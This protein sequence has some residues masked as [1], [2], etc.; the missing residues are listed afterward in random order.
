MGQVS[1]LKT[2]RS[3]LVSLSILTLVFYTSCGSRLFPEKVELNRSWRFRYDPDRVGLQQKWYFSNTSL[4]DWLTV[5]G[6]SYWDTNYNGI[7]WFVQDV[8]LPELRSDR[9]I[10]L[11]ITGASDRVTAWVNDSLLIEQADGSHLVYADIAKV[12]CPNRK[13][14]F[15]IM[16]EDTG[17]AGGLSGDVYLRKYL[18]PEELV[19]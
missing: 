6:G 15:V 18:T 14:R 13:N 4:T 12:Y 10:A 7:G 19:K 2:A 5:P 8:R 17:G 16:V 11:V 9:S 1:T 3:A